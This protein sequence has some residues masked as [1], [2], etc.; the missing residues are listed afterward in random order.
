MA[1]KSEVVDK[2]AK[3]CIDSINDA[4]KNK[5]SY[6]SARKF[7][8]GKTGNISPSIAGILANFFNSIGEDLA[9]GDTNVN[10]LKG[11]WNEGV[12]AQDDENINKEGGD[13][14]VKEMLDFVE[15]AKKMKIKGMFS[16]TAKIRDALLKAVKE[17][18]RRL[19]LEEAQNEKITKYLDASLDVAKTFTKNLKKLISGNA[20]DELNTDNAEE[21]NK[22]ITRMYNTLCKLAELDLD[23]NKKLKKITK[24]NQESRTDGLIPWYEKN[25]DK[26]EPGDVGKAILALYGAKGGFF[27]TSRIKKFLKIFDKDKL[28]K[29]RIE[30]ACSIGEQQINMNEEGNNQSEENQD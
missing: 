21:A 25:K 24:N 26:T 1:Q 30:K 9:D 16:R 28:F 22:Q 10:N 14:A 2:A 5:S 4:I 19:A 3:Q 23:K 7:L 8:I 15:K 18:D 13:K 11:G 17:Y 20:V 29:N 6:N 12:T 27:G